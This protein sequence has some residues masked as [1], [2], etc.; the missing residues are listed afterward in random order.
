MICYNSDDNINK[1]PCVIAL[2]NFDGVHRGHVHLLSMAREYAVKN[3]LKFGVYT[4]DVHPKI[5]CGENNFRLLNTNA[6]RVLEFEN[7]GADFVYFEDFRR[8]KDFDKN[9]FVAYLCE[10]FDC[11]AVFCGENFRYAKGASG[12]NLTLR[13]DMEKLGRKAFSV[14][15]F[16]IDGQCVSSSIIRKLLEEGNVEKANELLGYDFSVEG[17]VVHGNNIGHT[18]GFPTVN[19]RPESFL[20]MPKFG[21]Y[22]SRISVEDK[23]YNGVT[24]IGI[25]PTVEKNGNAVLAETNIFGFAGNLYGQYVKVSLCRMLREEKRF[26]SLDQLRNAVFNDIKNATEYF[27]E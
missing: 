17:K 27:G 21:V 20:V 15:L 13:D 11:Q 6:Q 23:M 22:A 14:S 8:V 5:V 7:N 25:K 16:E 4:F 9:A 12:T 24:N 26:E 18:L 10:K 1:E 3:G 19:V 2:G